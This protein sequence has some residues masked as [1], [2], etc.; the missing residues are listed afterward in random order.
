[1]R[2]KAC[3]VMGRIALRNA[4]RQSAATSARKPHALNVVK[5]RTAPSRRPLV[6]VKLDIIVNCADV[7]NSDDVMLHQR[8]DLIRVASG[9][10]IRLL[11]KEQ[12]YVTNSP[13]PIHFFC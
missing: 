2:L 11:E 12:A 8:R 4:W 1:M 6:V 7:R 10:L 13:H 9:W 3:Y 5:V